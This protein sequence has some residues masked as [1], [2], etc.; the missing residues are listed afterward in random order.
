VGEKLCKDPVTSAEQCV[1]DSNPA[2]GCDPATCSSCAAQVT[3]HVAALSYSCINNKCVPGPCPSPY[4]I[5]DTTKT[6]CD[7]NPNTDPHNCS[8]CVA[9][10]GTDCTQLPLGPNTVS[11]GCASALCKITSCKAGFADCDGV[12]TNGC[13]VTLSAANCWSCPLPV[14]GDAGAQQCP[15]KQCY[16]GTQ[17]LP[18]VCP[19]CNPS[20]RNCNTSAMQCQ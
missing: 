19:A 9:G 6:Y 16:V 8:N 3:P 13:E 17:G 11:I 14:T 2:Y 12:T 18:T 4:L 10:G 20:A 7:S 1:N 15:C 5:C